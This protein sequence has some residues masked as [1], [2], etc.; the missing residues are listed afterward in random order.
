MPS[1]IFRQTE[2]VVFYLAI[3]VC[4]LDASGLLEFP[5]AVPFWLSDRVAIHR[6][7]GAIF[8]S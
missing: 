4:N 6:Q 8:L 7:G 2:D 1:S 3:V 5:E